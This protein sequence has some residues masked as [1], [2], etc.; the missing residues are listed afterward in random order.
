MTLFYHVKQDCH[1]YMHFILIAIVYCG[2]LENEDQEEEGGYSI[3]L[4]IY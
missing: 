1:N 2:Q 4:D 3:I